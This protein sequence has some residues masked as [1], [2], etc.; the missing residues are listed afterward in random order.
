L[1]GGE[2][3]HS[4]PLFPTFNHLP[5]QSSIKII[6]LFPLDPKAKQI[7][8]SVFDVTGKL[9]S[10]T[11]WPVPTAT[12]LKPKSSWALTACPIREKGLRK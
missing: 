7:G 12:P 8:Y 9:I 10:G 2:L 6:A 1:A 3:F 4:N 11:A 5:C